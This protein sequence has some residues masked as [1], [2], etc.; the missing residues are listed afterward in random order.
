[1][2]SKRKIEIFSAGCAACDET[3]AIV[4][5][6]ACVSCDVEILDMHNPAVA[7][8]AKRYGVRSIPAVAIVGRLAARCTGAG[9]DEASLRAAGIG[10]SL[11]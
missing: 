7:A 2:S 1:M 5:R 6:I 8:N 9:S 11:S 4:K 3:V 10:V